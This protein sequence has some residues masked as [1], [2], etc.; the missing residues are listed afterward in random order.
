MK[1]GD[2]I[3]IKKEA[4]KI[5]KE[6][7]DAFLLISESGFNLKTIPKLQVIK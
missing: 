2:I 7:N 3:N 4:F 5:I 6:Y 1:L